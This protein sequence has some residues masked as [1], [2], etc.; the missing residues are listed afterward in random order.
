MAMQIMMTVIMMTD[1]FYTAGIFTEPYVTS[2]FQ[3]FY[4]ALHT[5]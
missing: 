4:E 1:P 2:Q 3:Y 5:R